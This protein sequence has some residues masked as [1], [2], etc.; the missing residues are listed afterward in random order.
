MGDHTPIAKEAEATAQRLAD[1]ARDAAGA[2]TDAVSDAAH[3]AKEAVSAGA[4]DLADNA[5][6]FADNAKIYAA[7]G[8]DAIVDGINEH[9]GV[10]ADYVSGV[11]ETLRVVAGELDR[12][13]PYAARYVR[14][15][16]DQVD[17]V[18][19]GVRS[20][21]VS[22]L[23]R[24]AQRFAR[25]QPTLVAGLA[26]LAGFGVVRLLRNASAADDAADRT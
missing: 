20:G 4:S 22:D 16:A 5:K 8:R 1:K 6:E 26:M 21:D 18:A 25:E 15:A 11:A 24:R 2:A 14:S 7:R 19:D 17:N 10:G 3:A 23:V 13:L 9:K 12:Q